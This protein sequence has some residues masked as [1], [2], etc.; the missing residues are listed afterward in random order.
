MTQKVEGDFCFLK[1]GN[2]HNRIFTSI[3]FFFSKYYDLVLMDFN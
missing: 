2:E 1:K 3:I